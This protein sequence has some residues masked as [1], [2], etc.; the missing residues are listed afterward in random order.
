MSTGVRL[1]RFSCAG[2]LRTLGFVVWATTVACG[3]EGE[4]GADLTRFVG[5]W[6][7]V[8]PTTLGGETPSG[9]ISLWCDGKPQSEPLAGVVLLEATPAGR[10]VF[11][12][13]PTC[14]IELA[15]KGDVASAKPGSECAL[16]IRKTAASGKFDAFTLTL[17]GD[18]L[19]LE[20]TGAVTLTIAGSTFSCSQVDASGA[21]GRRSSETGAGR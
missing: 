3:G 1:V 10:L 20:A 21:L 15:V 4:E 16:T 18:E 12:A 19:W 9:T 2:A 11:T 8:E 14:K 5:E 13:S 17:H 6:V 7:Y